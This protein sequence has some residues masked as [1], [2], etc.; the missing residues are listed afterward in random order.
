MSNRK[1]DPVLT[2]AVVGDG[3]LLNRTPNGGCVIHSVAGDTVE[4]RSF[5]RIAAAWEAIDA[6]DE[7][8]AA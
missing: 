3:V 6:L 5:D 1:Q 7:L 8:E 4:V 2:N